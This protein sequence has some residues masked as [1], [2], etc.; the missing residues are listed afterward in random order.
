[1]KNSNS[2]DVNNDYPVMEGNGNN[3]IQAIV[4][5]MLLAIWHNPVFSQYEQGPEFSNHLH[6]ES[7]SDEWVNQSLH[8]ESLPTDTDLAITLDQHLYPVLV[9]L[10]KKY[11]QL[12]KLRIAVEEGTCGISAGAL[13]DKKVDIGGF[14]CPAGETDRLPGLTYHTLAVAA[15]ALIVHPDNPVTDITLKQAQDIY[16][17]KIGN[18]GELAP[19]F[20]VRIQTVARLHCKNRPGHWR[21]ILDDEDMFSPVVH[22]VS[23]IRDM[24]SAT[25]DRKSSLGYETLWMA[26]SHADHGG[27]RPLNING[28]SPRDNAALIAGDYPF[29]RTYNI[30]TWSAKHLRKPHADKLVAYIYEHFGEIDPKFGLISSFLLRKAGWK[31]SANELISSP[32]SASIDSKQ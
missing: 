13:L 32:R 30:S 18:W 15:L 25:S 20:P 31:F 5:L 17:G 2:D 21:L 8:Y 6:S 27:V 3:F 10:V 24:I 19:E 22:E 28:N 4:L 7:M 29:Y 14:C 26:R 11:A 16:R 9:P 1:M 23:T 12:H